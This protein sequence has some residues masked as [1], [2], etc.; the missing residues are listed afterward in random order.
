MWQDLKVKVKTYETQIQALKKE[1]DELKKSGGGGSSGGG[2]CNCSPLCTTVCGKKDA[3]P[4]ASGAAMSVPAGAV[5]A[6]TKSTFCSRPDPDRKMWKVGQLPYPLSFFCGHV[7]ND[8]RPYVP[9][10]KDLKMEDVIIG[11]FSGDKMGFGR[12]VFQII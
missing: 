4:A 8:L 2:D 11:V 5:T 6:L 10:P 3:A 12:G 7:A 9:I 1:I